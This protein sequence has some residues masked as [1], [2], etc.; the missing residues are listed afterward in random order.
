MLEDRPGCLA[1]KQRSDYQDFS[2][3]F[4]RKTSKSWQAGWQAYGYTTLWVQ[5]LIESSGLEQDF[6]RQAVGMAK[7]RYALA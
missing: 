1:Q 3:R 4:S 6:D 2:E 7:P 5:M